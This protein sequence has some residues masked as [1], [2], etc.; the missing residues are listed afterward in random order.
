[1]CLL[2]LG[3]D[4]IELERYKQAFDKYDEVPHQKKGNTH[5]ETH[6]ILYM[7]VCADLAC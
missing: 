6:M 4:Y 5:T 1:M 7:L 2:R 3:V